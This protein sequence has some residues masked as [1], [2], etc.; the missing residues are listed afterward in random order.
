MDSADLYL[1][2]PGG[3]S[4]TEAAAKRLPMVYI[5]AV[6]GCERHNC[7]F[8]VE[9]GGAIAGANVE[10]LTRLC[11]KLLRNPQQRQEMSQRLD[12]LNLE[13]APQR[14]LRVLEEINEE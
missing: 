9:H 7:R 13:D 11:L 5:D 8:F 3:L 6:A 14:I 1:T 12:D 4:V 2:K 10:E